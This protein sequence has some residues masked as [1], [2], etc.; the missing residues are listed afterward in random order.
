MTVIEAIHRSEAS[1]ALP[2]LV[3]AVDATGW[4]MEFRRFDGGD[5]LQ[6]GAFD[7]VE[8]AAGEP[9]SP[10]NVDVVLAALV[11]FDSH[12]ARIGRGGGHYDQAFGPTRSLE[13]RPLLVG[14][15]FEFQRVGLI[16][17]RHHDVDMD[18]IVT[19]LGVRW[20][21]QTSSVAVV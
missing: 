2:A 8:P 12:G 7:I 10:A 21:S 20:A 5:P 11:A 17:T 13:R 18:A 14:I 6:V 15:G 16:E 1:L 9:V 19:E 3:P 4:Q